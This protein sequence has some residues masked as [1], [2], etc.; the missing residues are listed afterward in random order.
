MKIAVTGLGAV[1]GWG[2]SAGEL[3]R[4]L[5][6]G[7]PAIR[8]PRRF[9]TTG[10]RTH[11]ASE[12][13]EPAAELVSSIPG[14]HRLTWADRFGLVAAL[15]ACR[16]A[17]ISAPL[18]GAGVFFGGSTAGMLEGEEYFRVLLGD[19]S[20]RLHLQDIASHQMNGPGDEVARRFQADGP[21]Q[22]LSSACAAGGLAL[23]AALEALRAGE[24]ELALAGGADSLCRLTY[25][26]FNSLR[27]VDEGVS[28]PFRESRAGLS[29]GEG[30]AVLVLEPLERAL[31]RGAKPLALLEGAGASC[32]AHH[33]TAPHPEGAGAALA[34]AA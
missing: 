18:A 23:G 21:V 32:D 20:H 15:E 29:L 22:T 12:V 34:L 17:G 16:Q 28:R 24:V 7:R 2:W 4:G 10:H 6:S 26:G 27:A 33:M 25:A 31:A 5:D 11:L 1:S 3:W 9:D 13:P 19:A 14:W 8:G 30:G